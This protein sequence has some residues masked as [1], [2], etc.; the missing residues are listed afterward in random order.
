MQSAEIEKLI[1]IITDRVWA[2]LKVVCKSSILFQDQIEAY[3]APYVKK[4]SADYHFDFGQ[5]Q[6]SDAILLCLNQ[7]TMPQLIAVAH[8]TAID[9]VTTQMIDFLLKGKPV[10]I[11]SS[12]PKLQGYRKEARYAV[13]R[14]L[15][16]A[17]QKT[18]EFDVHFIDS[19]GQ[20]DEQFKQLRS[21]KSVKSVSSGLNKRHFVTEQV[22]EQRWQS[23]QQPL[24]QPGEVLTDLAKELAKDKHLNL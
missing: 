15:Q 22:L 18:S 23:N 8:L 7:V 1:Q 14:Q 6:D 12:K 11:F 20:F 19:E 2:Q 4:L 10:W 13:W 5:K 17:I 16:T 9:P 24:L 3:P 21:K